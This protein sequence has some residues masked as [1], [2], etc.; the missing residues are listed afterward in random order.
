MIRTIDEKLQWRA[1]YYKYHDKLSLKKIGQKLELSRAEVSGCI[2]LAEKSGMVK[3]HFSPPQ[4]KEL[5]TELVKLFKLKDAVVAI[6]IES[7]SISQTDLLGSVAAK[8]FEQE[9]R[10]YIKKTNSKIISIG[11]ACGKAIYSLIQTFR[12]FDLG[13]KKLEIYPLVAGPK[14]ESTT[15]AGVLADQFAQLFSK[16][17]ASSFQIARFHPVT[18]G[19]SK[20][21]KFEPLAGAIE[22]AN[23]V[24]FA[25]VG[26]GNLSADSTL[27]KTLQS[28]RFDN[29]DL[30]EIGINDQAGFDELIKAL[31]RQGVVGDICS[32]L[33]T[34]KG[35][36]SDFVSNKLLIGVKPDQL[37]NLHK[38]GKRVI[39]IS[40]GKDKIDGIFAALIGENGPYVDT[41]ITDE[42][43]AQSLLEMKR[44]QVTV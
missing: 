14:P 44:D 15:A 42:Y 21:L 27:G 22:I 35:F 12:P 7:A 8:Y 38:S 1:V 26:I 41:L 43:T 25:I 34:N 13:N 6:T 11:V 5:A 19:D 36:T 40:G 28:F 4:S 20:I 32:T 10:N 3:F 30:R 18:V 16:N 9:L 23:N 33:I 29:E 2:K 31:G 37:R 39:G 24:D 17:S